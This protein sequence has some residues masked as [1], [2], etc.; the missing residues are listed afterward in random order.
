MPTAMR[1]YQT[2]S[3]RKVDCQPI[4]VMNESE[5][6]V[7]DAFLRQGAILSETSIIFASTSPVRN[8]CGFGTSFVSF[9]RNN[10]HLQSCVSRIAIQRVV[11]FEE[12]FDPEDFV[13][14]ALDW[15]VPCSVMFQETMIRG[16]LS[17]KPSGATFVPQ[18]NVPKLPPGCLKL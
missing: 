4:H 14:G 2:E 11:W 17:R 1:L 7:F 16:R 12:R 18:H 13:S 6:I 9:V 3:P 15:Y 5:S 8:P 10:N